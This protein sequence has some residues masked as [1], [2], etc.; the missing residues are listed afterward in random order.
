MPRGVQRAGPMAPSKL[1]ATAF[2]QVCASPEFK[3][4]KFVT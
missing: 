1:T 3:A 2:I 4:M